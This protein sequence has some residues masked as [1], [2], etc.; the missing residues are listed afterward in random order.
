LPAGFCK[1]RYSSPVEASAKAGW[2]PVQPVAKTGFGSL[3]AGLGG[4]V[5]P[6]PQLP[7]LSWRERCWQAAGIDWDVCP[8]R[9]FCLK[10]REE[11]AILGC[12]CW[13]MG[14]GREKRAAKELQKSPWIGRYNAHKGSKYM[15]LS[16][17]SAGAG[18]STALY[19]T[20]PLRGPGRYNA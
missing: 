14:P 1:I 9:Q 4:K 5:K 15:R 10:K 19:L 6:P 16:R 13:P 12:G 20:A 11:T 3:P 17:H 7:A 2:Y 18:C 8:V